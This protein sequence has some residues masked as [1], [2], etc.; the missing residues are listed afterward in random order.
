MPATTAARPATRP[1]AGAGAAGLGLTCLLAWILA[2]AEPLPPP[3]PVPAGLPRPVAPPASCPAPGSLPTL[4]GGQAADPASFALSAATCA[5]GSCHGGQASPTKDVQSFAATLWMARDPHARA[6]ETLHEPRSLRMA[7]L[8][9]LGPPH[10]ERQCLLCHSVQA[11]REA[12]LPADVVADGVSCSACHGD[13]TDWLAL[14]HL[15]AWKTTPPH[16]RAALG[17]RDAGDAAARAR[18]CVPCHV[19]DDTREVGHDLIAAGHPRLAFE[20][21][22]YER[23]WPRHWNPRGRAEAEADFGERSWAAGQAETLAATARLLAARSERA[24]AGARGGGAVRGIDFAEFDCYACHRA[25]SP[26]RVAAGATGPFR[27]PTPGVPSWQP[28][29][30][31]AARLMA[32]SIDDPAGAAVEAAAVDVREGFGPR[33]AEGDPD[34]LGEVVARARALERAALAA[35][36]AVARRPRMELDTSGPRIDA[37]VGAAA[38]EWRFWDA[39]TQTY[40]L[41]EADRDGGP[42]R[43]GPGLTGGRAATDTRAAL[44]RLRASL[45]FA[46][47]SGGPDRFDP[48][49]FQD[50]RRA[51]TA[52]ARAPHGLEPTAKE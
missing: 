42:A 35:G 47:G 28:W 20:F 21:A 36:A 3:E 17:Y 14:H 15:P 18:S 9:G 45:R 1:P 38:P 32:L 49:A 30:M 24:A 41:M 16:E 27:N 29:A 50:G 39:A 51:L 25:L 34:R 8:L 43:L 7:A 13:A 46:P 44:D 22:A 4:A 48:A 12:P 23:L 52:P 10:R 33:W 26:E 37:A 31:S 11:E 40:L 6:C 19:G 2:A 5:T